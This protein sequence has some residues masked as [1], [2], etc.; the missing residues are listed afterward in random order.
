M[1]FIHLSD[2]H[3]G[4]RVNEFS[5]I[6]DQ[7]YIVKK[8]VDIIKREKPDAVLIAGDIYDKS[9]PSVEAVGLFDDFLKNLAGQQ[10]QVFIISGNHDSPERL[11]FASELI[12]TSGIH[13]APVYQ[14]IV[15][16]F[17]LNDAYGTV[18][19]Y[20]LP[21][22]KPTH[23]R[24]IFPEEKIESYTDALR[25][26]LSH[27]DIQESKRNILLTHQ[28]VT[29]AVRSDSEEISVGGSDNVDVS[30]F[31]AFDYVAL[32][33]IHGPQYVGRESVRYCGT[34]LKYSFS[35]TNHQKS[36]SVV[37]LKEK[38]NL[39]IRTVDLIP[40]HDLRELKGTYEE[41]TNK[42]NYEGTAV[43][44]YIHITL[45]DEEDILDAVGKL[46]VIYP[47]LMKLDY[48]NKRTRENRE[49]AG[50]EDIETK[51]PLELI[52]DFYEQQNNQPM[53]EKQEALTAELIE[54]IWEEK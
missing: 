52:L 22:I 33:H 3:L 29:G 17:S 12:E 53:N 7:K 48:D 14:G 16:P 6:E 4:K 42:K 44:D 13:I 38:G 41:L 30:V 31:N 11:A 49:I 5:M 32:G 24:S 43:D 36:V 50:G 51:T 9:I 2:L 21:F 34:P 18:N 35:E 39:S 54:K 46:R 45:T 25:I 19:I 10:T 28:F 15:R 27:M 8:I 26:A 1:K 20:M 40:L 23:V 47:N 37:E